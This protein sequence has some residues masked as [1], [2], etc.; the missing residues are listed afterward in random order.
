MPDCFECVSPAFCAMNQQCYV[1]ELGVALHAMAAHC[2]NWEGNGVLCFYLFIFT[3][4]NCFENRVLSCREAWQ[5]VV[6]QCLAK[7]LLEVLV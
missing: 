1:L 3:L 4:E 5:D 2:K 6:F 7:F